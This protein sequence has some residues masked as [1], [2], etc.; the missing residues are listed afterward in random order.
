MPVINSAHS[1]EFQF[2]FVCVRRTN[3]TQVGSKAVSVLCPSITHKARLT[4]L[5]REAYKS[6]YYA[7]YFNTK[8]H[9]APLV[10]TVVII[11]G[12]RKKKSLFPLVLHCQTQ[13]VVFGAFLLLMRVMVVKYIILVLFG[14][15]IACTA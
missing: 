7:L 13:F 12:L 4:I 2:L 8:V 11:L 3:V 14:G 6:F 5:S 1:N 9:Y 15:F 10:N